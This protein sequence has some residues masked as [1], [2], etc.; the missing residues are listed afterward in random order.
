[1]EGK[2]RAPEENRV[3]ERTRRR[4]NRKK[5]RYITYVLTMKKCKD[6]RASQKKGGEIVSKGNKN[7]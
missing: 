6:A 3:C 5:F 1:M 2:G 4:I 7:Y